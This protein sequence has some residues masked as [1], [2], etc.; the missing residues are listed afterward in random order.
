[1]VFIESRVGVT[2]SKMLRYTIYRK[3]CRSNYL[4]LGTFSAAAITRGS[5]SIISRTAAMAAARDPLPRTQVTQNR[6]CPNPNPN[7]FRRGHY[8][9]V[10][11]YYFPDRGHGRGP[12]PPPADLGGSK[13]AMSKP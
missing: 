12:G 9:G 3:C 13:S 6:Q 5:N 10:E 11:L 2:T 1:M 7:F 4:K 8:P